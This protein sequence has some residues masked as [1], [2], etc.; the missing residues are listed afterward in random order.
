LPTAFGEPGIKNG[1]FRPPFNAFDADY[2]H[3]L[4]I[5]SLT[6]PQTNSLG[7]AAFTQ[8]D[9]YW[10]A[11]ILAPAQTNIKLDS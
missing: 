11:A 2:E 3:V 9:Q 6:Q 8:T 4:F 1:A 5:C 10:R 7:L